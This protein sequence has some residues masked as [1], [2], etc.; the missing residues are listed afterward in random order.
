MQAAATTHGVAAAEDVEL[1]GSHV[2]RGEYIAIAD[3][4]AAGPV[5]RSFGRGATPIRRTGS[6]ARLTEVGM[7]DLGSAAILFADICESTKLYESAGDQEAYQLNGE[8]LELMRD[9]AERAGGTVI[10]TQGDGMLCTFPTARAALDAAGEMQDAHEGRRVSIKIGIHFGPL[11]RGHGGDIYGDAV[12]M[13]AR[14]SSQSRPGETLV[15]GDAVSLLP[16]TYQPRLRVLDSTTFKGKT[17][18]SNV[19]IVAP[20][21]FDGTETVFGHTPMP[22]IA[23]KPSSALLLSHGADSLRLDEGRRRVT[24]GR[25]RQC[26]LVVPASFASRVHAVVEVRRGRYVL[27]D[28]STNGTF[29]SDGRG[30]PL[31]LKRESTDLGAEGTISLGALPALDTEGIVRFK[32]VGPGE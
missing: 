31:F 21:K 20:Q 10:R 19:Y 5:V 16:S 30:E 11:L 32:R 15:S 23:F 27:T 14:I 24:L 12:N 25:D 3:R 22:A 17:I 8:S 4:F 2:Q 18:P 29:V 6:V 26:D 9:A 1:Q 28:Q 13:A 7:S